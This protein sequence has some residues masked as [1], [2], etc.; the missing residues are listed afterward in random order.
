MKQQLSGNGFLVEMYLDVFNK[1]V[2][3]D[4]YIGIFEECI[5]AAVKASIDL[6]AEKLIVKARSENFAELVEHGFLYEATVEKYYSGS[7]GYFFAKYF[8]NKRRNSD[9]WEQEDQLLAAVQK[10][11]SQQDHKVIPNEYFL[12][13][14]ELTD[15]EILADLYNTV[16]DI[17]PV[18]MNDPDYV[19]SCMKQDTAFFIYTYN[20]EIVSSTSAEINTKYH[21][22]E[23]TDC[24][25]L[26]EHRQFGLMKQLIVSLEQYLRSLHIYCCYSI[27]R[28]LS[29]GMNAALSSLG[30]R[31]G[32]RLANN[33]YIFDKLEDMN[34]WS[35]HVSH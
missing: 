20:G 8:T 35:K 16:F 14:A 9:R 6:K 11:R 28:S 2:R 31:Y 19:K 25:T 30:Y 33:C 12:R 10:N 1:R 22:A 21:N 29:Y 4:D 13:K 15:A 17:Y 23:I 32:G 3:V 18:P 7:D 5:L 26:P 27:A 34:L 24:A